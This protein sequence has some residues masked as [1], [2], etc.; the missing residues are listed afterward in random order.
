MKKTAIIYFLLIAISTLGF[1]ENTNNKAYGKNNIFLKDSEGNNII[2]KDNIIGGKSN[3]I[4]DKYLIDIFLQNRNKSKEEILDIIFKNLAQK[5]SKISEIIKQNESEKDDV[6]KKKI[7]EK[8]NLNYEYT[9][10]DYELINCLISRRRKGLYGVK[11]LKDIIREERFS[12]ILDFLITDENKNK[13]EEEIKE[14]LGNMENYLNNNLILGKKNKIDFAKNSVVLGNNIEIENSNMDGSVVIG[15]DNKAIGSGS[16]VIGDN[17]KTLNMYS[18]ALGYNCESLG[19]NSITIGD[20]SLALSKFSIAFGTNAKVYKESGIA[21]GTSTV[22]NTKGGI[23]LGIYSLADDAS[24]E[25]GYSPYNEI[26][27]K[28]QKVDIMNLDNFK[29]NYFQT[30]RKNTIWKA[31]SGVLSI[32]SD[33]NSSIDAFITRQISNVAAGYY[34]TDAVNVAQ[35]KELKTY[36]DNSTPFEY[37]TT[38]GKSL[39]K[40]KNKYYTKDNKEY[41]GEVKIKAKELFKLSNIKSSL[42]DKNTSETTPSENSSDK[43]DVLVVEDLDNIKKDIK[44]LK[45]FKNKFNDVSEKSN[46]A[47]NG[48]SNAVAMANL[49]QVNKNSECN[50]MVAYGFYGNSHSVALGLGGTKNMF[51]YKLSGSINNSGNIAV[52][53]GLGVSLK[54]SDNSIENL[55]KVE[56]EFKE[57]KEQSERKINTYIKQ[58]DEY[59]ARL[60]K[61]EKLL[62]ELKK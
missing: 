58:M 46:L 36:V 12:K 5:Y 54:K 50:L 37:A 27:K 44:E 28:Y 17:S 40:F 39:Y 29:G 25:E 47:M 30:M 49:P 19:Q 51:S 8:L 55:S 26:D 42:N 62:L 33:K 14:Y 16:I 15:N 10:Y 18:I 31:N 7:I 57:Y 61:L 56:K 4:N 21:I 20:K 52:G 45:D 1:S 53:L 60:E 24:E 2:G 22:A 23:A 34:D 48:I 6:I 9:K 32:G 38:E 3:E 35:L 11:A 43:N 13:S 59:K 41:T